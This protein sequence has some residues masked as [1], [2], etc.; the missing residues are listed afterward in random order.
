MTAS[1]SP[2]LSLILPTVLDQAQDSVG[3]L[4]LREYGAI[5]VAGNG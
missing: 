3:E 2:F 5:F 4:L 1:S